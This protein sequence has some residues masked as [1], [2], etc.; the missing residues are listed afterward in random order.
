MLVG[1][2][3]NVAIVS[4]VSDMCASF[5]AYDL[6]R[7]C[8]HTGVSGIKSRLMFSSGSLTEKNRQTIADVVM[9]N[10]SFT[11]MMWLD[12]D[13]RFPPDTLER[14]L[15]H[16]K[17][18]VCASYTERTNPFLP[19]TFPDFEDTR[20]RGFTLP[21]TTGLSPID[22]CG[23]GCV[24]VRTSVFEKLE[25]P[26]FIVSWNPNGPGCHVGEDLF[27]FKKAKNAGVQ[28]WQDH[29][30]TKELAHIGRYEFDYT[31]A[32]RA[33][34]QREAQHE[35]EQAKKEEETSGNLQL[36]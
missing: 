9:Q 27:F 13:M 34:A 11:H 14:L 7:L 19:V 10:G 16:D 26:Y 24:L 17:D 3:T 18:M 32:L 8:T 5:W 12:S 20:S 22:A 33:Q 31:H 1:K 4:P 30:L 29:D 2:E 35:A 23:F 21:D 25:R 28:L 36:V 6:A 15:K